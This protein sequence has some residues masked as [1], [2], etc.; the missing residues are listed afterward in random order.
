M[1]S[2]HSQERFGNE[3]TCMNQHMIMIALLCIVQ[4]THVAVGKMDIVWRTRFGE[5]GRIQT[6]QLK[7]V[8]RDKFCQQSNLVTLTNSLAIMLEVLQE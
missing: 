4:P 5:K 3:S 7:T 8:V 2:P 6:G 1:F